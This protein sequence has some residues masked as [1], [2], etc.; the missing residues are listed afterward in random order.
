MS[1]SSDEQ[2]DDSLV[3]RVLGGDRAA[4]EELLLR[5]YDWMERYV[6]RF[7][8]ASNRSTLSPED[9]IQDVYLQVFRKI[10]SFEP[11]GRGQL[12]AW[13]Q[14]IARNTVFD[15]LR[16]VKRSPSALCS[17]V[18]AG[19]ES[20][21]L[22]GLI[23]ELAVDKNSR[24]T[25]FAR[26][27]E[28]RSAFWVAMGTLPT[29]YRQAVELLYVQ[30]LPIDEVAAQMGKTVDAIRGIRMRARKQLQAS[31]VRLSRYV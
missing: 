8:P 21:E 14:T 23:E 3:E 1:E 30:E 16:K 17:Q 4:L 24:V 7:L 15:A 18:A 20:G 22:K 31:L 28:L 12:F 5:N 27:K 19:S 9:I 2:T 6:K 13:L 25:Q 26:E 11:Q 29:E 10:G